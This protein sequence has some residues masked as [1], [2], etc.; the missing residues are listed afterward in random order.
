MGGMRGGVSASWQE[1]VL[2]YHLLALLRKCLEPHHLTSQQILNR[3][4]LRFLRS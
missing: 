3:R 1:M 4:Y 2:G